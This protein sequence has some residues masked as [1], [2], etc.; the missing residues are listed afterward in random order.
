DELGMP[1]VDLADEVLQDPIWERSG[2]TERGRDACRIPM[3]WSGSERSYGFSA[4]ADTWLPMPEG[5]TAL[6]AEA[7]VG[8]PASIQSLYRSAL[9]LR[10]S[11]PAFAGDGLD[12]LPAPDGC[13]AFRRPGGLVCLVNLSGA[14]M[15]LPEGQ[16]LLA[17]ADLSDDT[18][19]DD[20]AVWLH[21]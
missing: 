18:L 7:Q 12:W 17:S 4:Q 9:A 14:A 11:S 2:H 21:A 3:P 5:W 8:D 16:V 6:T 1:D 15:P 13:L 19:P 20:S 10:A